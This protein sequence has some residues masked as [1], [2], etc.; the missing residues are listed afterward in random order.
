[1]NIFMRSISGK[2]LIFNVSDDESVEDLKLKVMERD[3]IYPEDQRLIFGGKH[4]VDG[5]FLGD[6]GIQENSTI[7]LTTLIGGIRFYNFYIEDQIITLQR[8]DSIQD[9]FN[10]VK[11]LFKLDYDEFILRYKKNKINLDNNLDIFHESPHDKI[12]IELEISIN[13]YIK[14]I[15]NE[16]FR[17][18]IFLSN[19]IEILKRKIQQKISKDINEITLL[20]QGKELTNNLT[21]NE[22]YLYE[23][24]TL[25]II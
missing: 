13:I 25:Q 2:S 7:I 23:N 1:M 12:D 18:N 4:L 17:I 16:K 5:D 9:L 10:R 21:L 11:Y 8:R 3:G 19:R 22:Y 6:Y 14:L 20:F 24:C 15:N